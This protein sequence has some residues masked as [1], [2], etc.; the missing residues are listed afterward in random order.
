MKIRFDEF[1]IREGEKVELAARPTKVK[2]LYK[3]RKHYRAL[4][5]KQTAELTVQQSLLFANSSYSLLLIFQAMD[6]AGKDS[7]IK[8]VMS[9]V[10]PQGCQV[11]SFK[12]PSTAELAHD[13]LWRTTRCLPERGQIGIFNRSYYEEVL[14][15]R[16]QPDVLLG[17]GLPKEELQARDFWQQRF[18]SMSS[19]E[20][21]LHLSGTRVVKFFLHLSKEEQRLRLLRRI[22]DPHRNWKFGRADIEQRKF[23]SHYQHAYE[24][25]LGA[26]STVD[27]PWYAVPADDKQNA[28]LIISQII[29]ETLKGLRMSYPRSDRAHQREL[30]AVR[31]LL[32]K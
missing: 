20:S 21:H 19:L 4:I 10:N 29:L 6:A 1:R 27:A 2:P 9:G 23:W 25:C 18:R 16:V 5:A 15:V 26:T 24:A 14:I 11:Y 32:V 30:Q 7:A 31:K 8:H 17:E 22:D 3:T 28:H 12:H 13:F